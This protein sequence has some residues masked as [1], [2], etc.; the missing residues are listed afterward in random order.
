MND[1]DKITVLER[2]IEALEKKISLIR[3]P[4]N[5]LPIE[6][7]SEGKLRKILHIGQEQIRILV[8]TGRLQA[9]KIRRGNK[10]RLRFTTQAIK[11]YQE[12]LS[13]FRQP[14]QFETAEEIA[15]RFFV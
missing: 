15:K 2:R 11:D 4:E 1:P 10:I 9:I 6:E 7:F 3:E 12:Q 14:Q 13:S 8:E 5:L